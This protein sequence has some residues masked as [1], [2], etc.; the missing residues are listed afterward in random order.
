[1][2]FVRYVSPF[3]RLAVVSDGL[4]YPIQVAMLKA[5]L[6]KMPVY[7]NK[8]AFRPNGL[9]LSFPHGSPTCETGSGV[10][11]CAVARSL[12]PATVVL[13]GDGR[14]D[15]CLA[16]SADHVFAKGSLIRFCEKENIPHTPFATFSDVLAVVSEWDKTT[17][18]ANREKRY[19]T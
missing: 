17:L 4:D 5:G 13:V 10:C 6:P 1:M 15:F 18:I 12:D 14:S 2:D 8:M 9:S 16:K 19:A 11:K 3:A 7:A